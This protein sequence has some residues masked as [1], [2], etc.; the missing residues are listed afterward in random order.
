MTSPLWCH[1]G[2]L[3]MPFLLM[4]QKRVLTILIQTPRYSLTSVAL[5][6]NLKNRNWMETSRV[7]AYKHIQNKEPLDHLSLCARA[8]NKSVCKQHVQNLPEYLGFFVLHF[9]HYSP[10]GQKSCKWRKQGPN[11]KER[12]VQQAL[13]EQPN[14][15]ERL[16]GPRMGRQGGHRHASPLHTSAAAGAPANPFLQS[17]VCPHGITVPDCSIYLTLNY[18]G[19]PDTK[20]SQVHGLC[21]SFVAQNQC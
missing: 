8:V 16:W 17:G 7:T 11:R 14:P 10:N 13:S 4:H 19:F 18:W 2:W 15:E 1:P 3:V 20:I 6:Y 21:N 9:R 12:G 5:I